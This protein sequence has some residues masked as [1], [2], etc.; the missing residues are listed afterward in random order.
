MDGLAWV[1][2][3]RRRPRYRGS[4]DGRCR[5]DLRCRYAPD[6][7]HGITYNPADGR[8]NVD[9]VPEV[10]AHKPKLEQERIEKVVERLNETRDLAVLLKGMRELFVEA[11]KD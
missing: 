4:A 1:R 10:L 2:R 9:L 5:L 3:D 8:S 11:M 6:G 7:R